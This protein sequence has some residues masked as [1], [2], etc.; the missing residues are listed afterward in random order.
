MAV[1]PGAKLS[2]DVLV[3]DDG[4][5]ALPEVEA[6]VTHAVTAAAAGCGLAF[7]A[8][9][10]VSVLLTCDA[11]VRTLNAQ[12]RGQD[13]PTNV[14]SFPAAA[15]ADLAAAAL[16]GDIALAHG[17]V[18]REAEA[19]DKALEDHLTHLVVHG[20][21]HLAGHDHQT[22]DEAERMEALER[23]ILAGLGIADPY[24]DET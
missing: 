15:P 3:E 16:I 23:T 20:F 11:A 6:L 17:V 8:G 22:A 14:L 12:W 5:A 19:E 18:R 1:P 10:E 13:K 9:A 2:V 4:W 21:L 24:R 7:R